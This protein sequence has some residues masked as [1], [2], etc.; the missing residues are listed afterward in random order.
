MMK[1]RVFTLGVFLSLYVFLLIDRDLLQEDYFRLES[2]EPPQ[3]AGVL[4][5]IL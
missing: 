5:F 1:L 2:K 4:N 3:N